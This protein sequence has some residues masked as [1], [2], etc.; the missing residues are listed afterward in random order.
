MLTHANLKYIPRALPIHSTPI[1]LFQKPAGGT[2]PPG[3]LKS[4]SPNLYA[5]TRMQKMFL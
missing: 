5:Q 4:I 1:E 3:L 2:K